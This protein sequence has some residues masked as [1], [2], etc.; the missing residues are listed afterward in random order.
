MGASAKSKSI[1]A[2]MQ[3]SDWKKFMV[4]Y[5]DALAEYNAD[6]ANLDAEK[7]NEANWMSG[8]GKVIFIAATYAFDAL[9]FP[10]PGSA[11]RTAGIALAAGGTSLAARGVTDWIIQAPDKAVKELEAKGYDVYDPVFNTTRAYELEKGIETDKAGEVSAFDAYEKNM[12]TGQWLETMGD[13]GTFM[14]LSAG[15]KFKSGYKGG[16]K[17]TFMQDP[18]IVQAPD[19]RGK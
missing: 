9:V 11:L 6:V 17:N 18:V 15:G 5:T 10:G 4:S 8:I 19:I 2:G 7:Q 12:W 13:M 14:A 16:G 1:L 3:S